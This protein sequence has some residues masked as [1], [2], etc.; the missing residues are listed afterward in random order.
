MHHH[1][2]KSIHDGQALP[3]M[4][5]SFTGASQS[6]PTV[7]VS[8]VSHVQFQ[9]QK[10]W[11][12]RGCTARMAPCNMCD[13]CG[14][15]L[16]TAS[17]KTPFAIPN[18]AWHETCRMPFAPCS[19]LERR[20]F[21]KSAGLSQRTVASRGAPRF[22]GQVLNLQRFKRGVKWRET[23]QGHGRRTPRGG[24]GSVGGTSPYEVEICR[25]QIVSSR[26]LKLLAGS[27][28]LQGC[29]HELRRT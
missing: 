29:R 25:N 1:T 24:D 7:L 21:L 13:T 6:H 8:S 2:W 4:L 18:T 15:A 3:R 23:W 22:Q 5:A 27:R 12:A 14:V 11:K 10:G 16:S 19:A 17:Q 9:K 20:I 28:D 26:D